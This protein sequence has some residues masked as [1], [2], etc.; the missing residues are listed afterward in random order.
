M[1]PLKIKCSRLSPFDA[2]NMEDA[3]RALQGC[4]PCALRQAWLEGEEADFQP[5]SVRVGWGDELLFVLA[6]LSDLDIYSDA[7]AHNQ[8]M[9]KLGDTFEMFLRPAEQQS[10]AEF[11][12]TP[13]NFRLQLRFPDA[14]TIT[15]IRGK[16]ETLDDY[17]IHEQVFH[18]TTSVHPSGRK[19]VVLAEIPAKAVCE[20]PKPLP[21]SRWFFSFSRF[22]YSR[23]RSEPV[24]SSTSP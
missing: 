10:Y 7:T 22:D 12:V 23:S 6:E 16:L 24:I 17:L 13:N 19:W 5:S 8:R 2:G 4:A 21:G 18:S 1:K 11:H 15:R 3:R 14:D 20:R 9:W